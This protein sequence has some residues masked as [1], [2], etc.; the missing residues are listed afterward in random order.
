MDILNRTSLA[1]HGRCSSYDDLTGQKPRVMSIMPFGCRAWAIKQTRAK[2]AI[3]STAIM[4]VNLG[5]S[6]RQPGSYV[7]WLPPEQRAVSTSD[8]LFDEP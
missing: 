4:G 8:A 2:T 1:P 3:E 6:E 5:R 7:I